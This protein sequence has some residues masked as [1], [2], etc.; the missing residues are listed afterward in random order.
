MNILVTGGAGFVGTNLIKKLL[1]QGYTVASIDNY[2][3]GL[4]SNHQQ[5]CIYYE[6]DIR[7]INDYSAFGKFDIVYHLAAIARIQPSFDNPVESFI[8][9]SLATFRLAH[10]CA[11][12]NIPLIYAGTSS[13]HSGKFK[14]PYTFT[15]D[16]GEDAITLFQENYNLKSS[17]ARFYNVYGPY[18]NEKGKMASVAYQMMLKNKNNEKIMLFPNKPTRDFVYVKDVVSANIYAYE[19]YDKLKSFYYE[20]GSGESRLFE[21][22]LNILEIPFSYHD[23]FEIP[24]GYQFYTKSEPLNWM[25]GW[26]PKYNLEKGLKEYKEWINQK[27]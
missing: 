23:E 6:Y 24:F 2:S 4:K 19:N 13:H 17:I 15:K 3:T 1:Q 25:D 18:E 26:E 22:V 7:T 9:N 16:I 11:I 27:S 20:V 14:N 10:Y 5:G 8:S 12:N 21:D